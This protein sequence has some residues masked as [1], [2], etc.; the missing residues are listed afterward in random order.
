M[1][2]RI[3]LPLLSLIL[4]FSLF[5]L[6]P[7]ARVFVKELYDRSFGFAKKAVSSNNSQSE[8]TGS[9]SSSGPRWVLVDTSHTLA[10]DRHN[11]YYDVTYSFEEDSDGTVRFT[12]SGGYYQDARN[13]FRSDDYYECMKPP[14]SLTPGQSITMTLKTTVKNYEHASSNGTKAGVHADTAWVQDSSHFKDVLDANNTYLVVPVTGDTTVTG[15]FAGTVS[16]WNVIG[17]HYE[18]KFCISNTGTY[19]WTYELQNVSEKVS[20]DDEDQSSADASEMV[21]SDD[22]DRSSADASEMVSSDDEDQSSAGV[23]GP[24]WVL[25]DTSHTLADDRH[26]EYYDVTY[27]FEEDS[28]GTVRFTRSGGYYQDARNYFRSDDYYEC[29]KPPASLTPGQSITM[30]LKTTVKNYEHASSNGTKA[31]VHADTAWVQDSSHFKD[32]LDANNTY[33]VVPVTGD[34]TVTGEFAGTVSTWNV[35]GSHY[36]IKFC[37]SNTGTYTWTYELQDN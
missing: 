5:S 12:R 29:M 19:T 18:I 3:Y 14:A 16:T 4:V 23:S 30:T 35:I 34:T 15:E 22:E 25:V 31:G 10:D 2:K 21:S 32:V 1:K 17:S 7:A 13:Y 27:S 37:I 6:V 26:N 8:N 28:D 24:R 36:E 9:A 11:E 20:S 33:L